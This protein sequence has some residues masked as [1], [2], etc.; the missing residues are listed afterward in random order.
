MKFKKFVK[1]NGYTY[2]SNSL[3][4]SKYVVVAMTG[5]ESYLGLQIL[6]GKTRETTLSELYFRRVSEFCNLCAA[7][8][9][10]SV[11]TTN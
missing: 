1:L 4:N 11:C 8:W 2:V 6:L 5:N 9:W 10:L 3:T 7:L